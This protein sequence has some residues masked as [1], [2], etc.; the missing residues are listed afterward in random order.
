MAPPVTEVVVAPAVPAP[1]FRPRP[2]E[3]EDFEVVWSGRDSL[4]GDRE[5]RGSTLSDGASASV[6]RVSR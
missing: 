2:I 1:V 3:R 6:A 5:S 4:I